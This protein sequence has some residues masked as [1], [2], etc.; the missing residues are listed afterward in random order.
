MM[1][2][3][4][5]SATTHRSSTTVHD[6]ALTASRAG[7]G[8]AGPWL[9]LRPFL[10]RGAGRPEDVAPVTRRA[11]RW[12]SRTAVVARRTPGPATFR[13]ARLSVGGLAPPDNGAPRYRK[14]RALALGHAAHEWRRALACGR[15]VTR[16]ATSPRTRSGPRARSPACRG[17]ASDPECAALAIT[18]LSPPG[19][20]AR[21]PACS[22]TA[23]PPAGRRHY[24]RVA[25]K[26]LREVLARAHPRR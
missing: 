13:S 4:V 24:T 23:A 14:S 6:S 15:A 25:I 9:W 3:R 19:P 17:R 21:W 22:F 8:R 16:P 2:G 18:V 20:R 7:R 26:D 1:A 10:A 11:G 12:W 5:L